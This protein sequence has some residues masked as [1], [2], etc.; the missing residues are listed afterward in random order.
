MKQ[1]E[2]INL[3]YRNK[4][5]LE[6]A[7]AFTKVTLVF[8]CSNFIFYGII[9]LCMDLCST[10]LLQNQDSEIISNFGN[11]SWWKLLMYI[12]I[13]IYFTDAIAVYVERVTTVVG[14]A[15][16]LFNIHFKITEVLILLSI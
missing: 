10:S 3:N 5:R 16:E 1:Y 8:I 7:F 12:Q 9:A 4:T 14:H 2:N 13:A 11:Y 15:N 6:H